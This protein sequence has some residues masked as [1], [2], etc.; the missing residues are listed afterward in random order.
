MKLSNHRN[1]GSASPIELSMT[2]MIDVVFLL[3][4]FFLVTSK[5]VQPERQVAADIR[6][7]MASG[8]LVSTDLQPAL[9][10]IT[11]SGGTTVFQL[12]AI[13]TSRL[14]DLK[15]P[16]VQ[17]SDKSEGAFV[18]VGDEVSFEQVAQAIAMCKSAGFVSVSYLPGD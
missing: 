8:N 10:E 13:R 3:L 5:I 2:A 14:L 6:A 1:H 12:G 11:H 15:T 4:I 9:I 16:L 17:F 18:R 7:E